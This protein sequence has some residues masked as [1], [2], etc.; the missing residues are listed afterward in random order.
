MPSLLTIVGRYDSSAVIFGMVR[1]FE[2]VVV[3]IPGDILDTD[4]QGNEWLMISLLLSTYEVSSKEKGKNRGSPRWP[5]STEINGQSKAHA[6]LLM[7]GYVRENCH[8]NMVIDI[9]SFN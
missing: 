2:E 3:L 7:M 4:T 1:G 5:A 8:H 6:R 9:L